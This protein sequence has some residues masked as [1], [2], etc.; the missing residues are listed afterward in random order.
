MQAYVAIWM[1][2]FD[3]VSELQ[4]IPPPLTRYQ[5]PFELGLAR[6]PAEQHMQHLGTFKQKQQLNDK[7]A[8]YL[9]GIFLASSTIPDEGTAKLGE[10]VAA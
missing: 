4:T 8:P 5:T 7:T 2:V 6:L 9:T 10:I 3:V 1:A